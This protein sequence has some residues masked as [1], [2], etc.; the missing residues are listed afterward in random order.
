MTVREWTWWVARVCNP[1]S[2][3]TD[4]GRAAGSLVRPVREGRRELHEHLWPRHAGEPGGMKEVKEEI[5]YYDQSRRQER[6]WGEQTS[7]FPSIRKHHLFR[8]LFYSYYC[9]CH[10]IL[11]LSVGTHLAWHTW[12]GQRAALWSQS[13]LSFYHGLQGRS[14]SQVLCHPLSPLAGSDHN[15]SFL[16]WSW[17]WA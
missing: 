17:D 3:G 12:G 5:I 1:K 11:V 9:V 14:W 4:T 10:V 7:C 6:S 15:F 8:E 16:W 13:G 2:Q